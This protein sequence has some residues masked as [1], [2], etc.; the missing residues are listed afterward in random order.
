MGQIQN[1]FPAL[2]R[3]RFSFLSHLLHLWDAPLTCLCTAGRNAS[4]Q[5]GQRLEHRPL[6]IPISRE[7]SPLS[8]PDS[9]DVQCLGALP[10]LQ[11]EKQLGALPALPLTSVLIVPVTEMMLSQPSCRSKMQRGFYPD[12]TTS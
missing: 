6:L 7:S 9:Q 4:V 2:C 10:S 3:L 11:P 12:F 8:A 1:F 5:C